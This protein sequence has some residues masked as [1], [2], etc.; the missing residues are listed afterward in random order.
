M[1]GWLTPL[2]LAQLARYREI[3]A[4]RMTPDLARWLEHG[5][6]VAGNPRGT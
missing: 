4:E 5:R 1:S 6:A 3:A 2:P